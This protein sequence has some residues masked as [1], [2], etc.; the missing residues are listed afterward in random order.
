MH[1]TLGTVI[2]DP[3][4]LD[5]IPDTGD[6]T[7]LR[8]LRVHAKPPSQRVFAPPRKRVDAEPSWP[9]RAHAPSPSSRATLPPPPP[10]A[11]TDALAR[12]ALSPPTIAL[13]PQ[14]LIHVAQ[15]PPWR[16][17]TPVPPD[18]SFGQHKLPRVV[19]PVAEEELRRDAHGRLLRRGLMTVGALLAL[20]MAASLT[21]PHPDAAST[22]ASASFSP[23]R[24]AGPTSQRASTAPAFSVVTSASGA[25]NNGT[26]AD[27]E[28]HPAS[29]AVGTQACV[30]ANACSPTI[31]EGKEAPR[32]G[33]RWLRALGSRQGVDRI[34]SDAP[35]TPA[36]RVV[37]DQSASA[38]RPHG[39]LAKTVELVEPAE[40]SRG[41]EQH[42]AKPLEAN[43]YVR[44]PARA[45]ASPPP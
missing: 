32:S 6:S 41:R 10:R 7:Q 27:S 44:R 8:Y 24:S 5:S 19:T 36:T 3:D 26:T 14:D 25:A 4:R 21:Q 43:P 12:A 33:R 22:R 31:P 13:E 37:A 42:S 15:P 34:P 9:P 11:P 1:P 30:A 20:G 23:A 39:A 2:A 28:R 17:F 35:A 45:E 18:L 38:A 40:L 16:R 29:G